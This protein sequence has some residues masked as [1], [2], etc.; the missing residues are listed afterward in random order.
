MMWSR[1]SSR[2]E[3]T[4]SDAVVDIADA[5]DG[6]DAM[7]AMDGMDGMDGMDAAFN[8]TNHV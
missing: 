8:C 1:N 2:C 5:M 4:A 7:D 6:I 3:G